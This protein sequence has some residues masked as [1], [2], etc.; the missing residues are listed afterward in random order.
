LRR[1][2][3]TMCPQFLSND[4]KTLYMIGHLQLLCKR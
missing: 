1:K 4:L 3:E 2:L